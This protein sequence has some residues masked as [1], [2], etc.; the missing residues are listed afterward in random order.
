[1][2]IRLYAL[3]ASFNSFQ[4]T[5]KTFPEVGINSIN[6]DGRLNQPG[7]FSGFQKKQQPITQH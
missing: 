3:T 1:M 2:L 7:S 4:I 5:Q 6:G